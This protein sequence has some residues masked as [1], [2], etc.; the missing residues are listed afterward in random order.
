MND[1]THADTTASPRLI[2]MKMAELG[3]RSG[4][5]VATI[6]FYLREGLLPAGEYRLPNQATYTDEHLR[7]LTMIRSLLEVGGLSIAAAKRVFHAIDSDMPLAETLE[8][9]QHAISETP[10]LSTLNPAALATV[11]DITHGWHI[12]PENPGRLAAARTIDTFWSI[13]QE[14]THGW[15]ARYAKAAMLAAEA[16]ID[17]LQARTSRDAQAETVVVGTL[18]GDA[19]FAALHRAAQEHVTSLRFATDHNHHEA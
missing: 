1:T 7:R 3:R 15:F 13:G 14:D 8:V 19:L 12:F 18:L 9:A 17:E 2:C 4:I 6:K 16:D 5:P 10:E 11:D